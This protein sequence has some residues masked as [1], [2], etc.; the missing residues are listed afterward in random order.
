MSAMTHWLGTSSALDPLEHDFYVGEGAGQDVM[1]FLDQ[2]PH[3][4]GA[5]VLVDMRLDGIE[6]AWK[7]LV[8]PATVKLT[9]SP[10]W[11]PGAYFPEP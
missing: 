3:L 5:G 7:V 10:A 1:E 11:I 9:T 8:K 6:R 2:G 4:E